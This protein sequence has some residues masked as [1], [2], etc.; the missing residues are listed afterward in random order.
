MVEH[1]RKASL[2]S[3]PLDFCRQEQ[4]VGVFDVNVPPESNR[5][6]PASD[7]VCMFLKKIA[8]R[9]E[10]FAHGHFFQ[11]LSPIPARRGVRGDE[12]D[13]LEP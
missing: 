5:T 8:R 12:R 11:L 1:E 4:Q 9:E 3:R 10:R 13:P 7:E 2:A 6:N